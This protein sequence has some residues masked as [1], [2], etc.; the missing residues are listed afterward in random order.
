MAT[1]IARVK[2]ARNRFIGLAKSGEDGLPPPTQR[3]ATGRRVIP[4]IMIIVPVTTGGNSL[5]RRL[6]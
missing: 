5:I 1:T 2:A 6:K 3:T 4:I